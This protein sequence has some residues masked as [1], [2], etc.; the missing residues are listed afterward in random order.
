MPPAFWKHHQV[1]YPSSLKAD[2]TLLHAL[3]C[4]GGGGHAAAIGQLMTSR[5]FVD[6]FCEAVAL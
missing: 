5:A 2:P 4:N 3:P 1:D 6:A